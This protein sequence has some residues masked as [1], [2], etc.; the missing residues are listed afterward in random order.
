M[1]LAQE[2]PEE[3]QPL[4]DRQQVAQH[5]PPVEEELVLLAVAMVEDAMVVVV[6]VVMVDKVATGEPQQQQVHPQPSSKEG[7]KN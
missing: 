3:Q 6:E 4:Q 7:T 5:L 1:L 2:I